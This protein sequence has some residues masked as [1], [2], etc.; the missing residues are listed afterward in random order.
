MDDLTGLGKPATKLIETVAGA[1]GTLFE[2]RRIRRRA[3]ARA[4]ADVMRMKGKIA[5]AE[6]AERAAH[7][8]Q[9]REVNRQRNLEAIIG[10]A[11]P[12]LPANVDTTPVDPDWT[13]AFIDCAQDVSD[14]EMQSLWARILAGEVAEPGSFSRRTLA[15]VRVMSKVDAGRFTRFCSF[16]WW[17]NGSGV[18]VQEPNSEDLFTRADVTYGHQLL[19]RVTGLITDEGVGVGSRVYQ[20]E[21][22]KEYTL[23]YFGTE[24]K[25]RLVGTTRSFLQVAP[26]TPVG[27]ELAPISGATRNEEYFKRCVSYFRANG[28]DIPDLPA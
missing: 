26:L 9:V 3:K 27:A 7:R 15:A 22:D 8:A 25:S 18:C 16:L 23:D 17:I 1:I 28:L 11:I 14:E 4:A 10:R 6:L 5:A 24:I 2:P 19:L 20:F 13:S 21:T 12:Q